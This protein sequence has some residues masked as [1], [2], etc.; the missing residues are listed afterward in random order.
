LRQI[1]RAEPIEWRQI[2]AIV[3]TH[4]HIRGQDHRSRMGPLTGISVVDLT[5]VLSGPF[6]TDA[7]EIDASLHA[8]VTA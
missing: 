5:R 6:C 8:S 2:V 4:P 3:Q 7:D 1:W